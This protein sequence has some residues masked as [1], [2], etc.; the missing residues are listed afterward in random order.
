MEKLAPAADASAVAPVV[1]NEPAVAAAAA[2]SDATAV[3]A[4]AAAPVQDTVKLNPPVNVAEAVAVKADKELTDIVEQPVD[5]AEPKA[6]VKK[7]QYLPESR[8]A[9][10]RLAPVNEAY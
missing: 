1:L 4:A 2:P 8:Y 10:K 9:K 6:V 5:A 3:V 7:V